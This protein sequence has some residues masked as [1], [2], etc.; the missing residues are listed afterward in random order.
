[1]SRVPRA[2]T[3]RPLD[4]VP[5]AGLCAAGVAFRAPGLTAADA[6]FDDAWAALPAHVPF[7]TA[8]HM[9]VT[10]PLYGLA[11]RSWIQLGPH[12]T[13]WGQLPAFALGVVGIVAVYALIRGLGLPRLGAF[14]AGLAIAVGPVT[15]AYSTRLKEYPSDLVFACLVLWLAERWRR[16]PSRRATLALAAAGVVSLWVS[17]STAAVVGGAAA[18]VVVSCIGRPA[19]VREAGLLVGALAAGTIGVWAAFLRLVPSQLRTNWRT[20]GYLFGYSDVHHVLYEFQQTFSG[21]THGL[22]GVPIPWTSSSSALRAV[23]MIFAVASFVG[24]VALVAVPVRAAVRTRF[25]DVGVGFAAAVTVALAILGTFVGVAPLGDGRTDEAFYPALLVLLVVAATLLATAA[26]SPERVTRRVRFGVAAAMGLVS[27]L[28]GAAHVAEYPP[29]GL[30]TVVAELRT[31]LLPGDVVVLDGYESFTWADE[32]LGAWHVSFRQG[33]VPWP[34]GFHVVSDNPT[35]VLSDEYLQPDRQI[36]DLSL[37]THRLW[38]LGPTVG[39]YS[40]QAPTDLWSFPDSTPIYD[41]LVALGWQPVGGVCC[42]APG[43]YAVLFLYRP[44][45]P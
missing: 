37:R 17:A 9:V 19:L 26:T 11:L 44:T 10:A 35:Y 16:E 38:Y 32:D 33:S 18:V 36:E 28:F 42:S 13:W 2:V 14:A 12:A 29:T 40:N 21:L 41:E 30:S 5:V 15:V 43:A 1:M 31:H 39:G 27:V 22:L 20:H 23:P 25:L 3:W 4:V 24:I 6:W 8:L 45:A 34:M 7:G